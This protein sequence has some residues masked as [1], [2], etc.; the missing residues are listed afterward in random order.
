MNYGKIVKVDNRL[1]KT[2][3]YA[4]SYT[5]TVFD[6]SIKGYIKVDIMSKFI[7][8]LKENDIC[9]TPDIL[10]VSTYNFNLN[11][12]K[13]LFD[14]MNSSDNISTGKATNIKIIKELMQ[15]LARTNREAF[16]KDGYSNIK[17]KAL[18]AIY[19][20]LEIDLS[21]ENLNA[22][23]LYKIYIDEMKDKYYKEANTLQ[24]IC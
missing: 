23:D 22:E 21:K 18:K 20:D 11:E 24:K 7:E 17:I 13:E 6:S 8:E 12:S 9:I 16:E 14:Y 5:D 3:K 4:L 19:N 1:I 10:E 15:S 2:L